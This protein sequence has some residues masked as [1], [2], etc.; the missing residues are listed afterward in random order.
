MAN[1]IPLPFVIA[2]RRKPVKVKIGNEEIGVIEIDRLGYLTTGEKSQFQQVDL[3]PEGPKALLGLVDKIVKETGTD[4]QTVV[5]FFGQLENVSEDTPTPEWLS[6][7]MDVLL[8]ALGK[9]EEDTIRANILKASVLL[10]NRLDAEIDIQQVMALDPELV[11][12]I[13]EL[14][15]AEEQKSLEA[16]PSEYVEE[17]KKEQQAAEAATKKAGKPKLASSTDPSKN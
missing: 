5:S 7:Y 4:K 16:L 11:Q 17:A 2:P 3:E 9:F 12:A 15:D 8:N 14:Y 13:A 6:P 10:L 1:K